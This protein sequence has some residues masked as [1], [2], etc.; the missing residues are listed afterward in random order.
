M[1]ANETTGSRPAWVPDTGAPMTANEYN[2][3]YLA[4]PD[5]WWWTTNLSTEPRGLVLSRVLAIIMQANVVVHEKAVGQLGAGPL[6]DMMSDELL[7]ELKVLHPFSPALK[8][9]L[10]CVRIGT[11]TARVRER[12][13][14]MLR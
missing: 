2:G 5:L 1:P 8:L 3:A 11:E 14:A 13:A 6:E 9:A 7:D 10:S 12:L 4:Q